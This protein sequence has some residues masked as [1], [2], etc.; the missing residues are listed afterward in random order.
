MRMPYI[1]IGYLTVINIAGFIVCAADKQAAI[2]HKR[3][4]SERALFVLALLGGALGVWLS[5]LIFHHKTRKLRFMFLMPVIA[6]VYTAL[7]YL[8]LFQ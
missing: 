3:R 8:L 1:L 7:A 2:K 6:L 5:M 4:V